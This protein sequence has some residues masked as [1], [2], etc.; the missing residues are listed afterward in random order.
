M[1]RKNKEDWYMILGNNDISISTQE[2]S[3]LIVI[4]GILILSLVK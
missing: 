2:F 1:M 3:I 4:D